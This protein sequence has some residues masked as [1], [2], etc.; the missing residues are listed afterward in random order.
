MWGVAGCGHWKVAAYT[1]SPFR[2]FPLAACEKSRSECNRFSEWGAVLAVVEL[3][4]DMEWDGQHESRARA[5]HGLAFLT[6]CC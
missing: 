4:W 1:R 6:L 2:Y 3:P 5:L